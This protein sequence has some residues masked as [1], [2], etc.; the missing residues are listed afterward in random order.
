MRLALTNQCCHYDQVYKTRPADSFYGELHADHLQLNINMRLTHYGNTYTIHG[1]VVL[2]DLVTLKVDDN[3]T[4]D[5]TH[6]NEIELAGVIFLR[7]SKW[8]I[9]PPKIAEW[10]STNAFLNNHQFPKVQH[11]KQS[12]SLGIFQFLHS[13]MS[14][15]KW[16]SYFANE[17][18][19]NQMHYIG[20]RTLPV[21][22]FLAVCCGVFVTS[23]I[24]KRLGVFGLES[25]VPTIT[26]V[27]MTSQIGPLIGGQLLVAQCASAISADVAE[28]RLNQE[29][30][31]FILNNHNPYH[32][33]CLPRIYACAIAYVF[34][35]FT[36]TFSALIISAIFMSY[37]LV[38]ASVFEIGGTII[39]TLREDWNFFLVII[40][41]FVYGIL[42][43]VIS[44][45][46]GCSFDLEEGV[47][48]CVNRAVFY[49]MLTVTVVHIV[50]GNVLFG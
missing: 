50:I 47:G 26:T 33:Y 21:M 39:A 46:I 20:W 49:A 37:K 5:L 28:A 12:R 32:C 24:L 2:S 41:A 30:D 45:Y 3:I 14:A 17:V 11:T 44:L 6:V 43:A 34:L 38:N 18:M 8:K 40:K 19:W 48:R 13:L 7:N 16:N 25:V 35:I 31:A 29:W 10:E 9:V 22:L 15:I 23:Q 4:L 27:I 1:S 42:T 36:L